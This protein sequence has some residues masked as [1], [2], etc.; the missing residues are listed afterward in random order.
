M[1]HFVSSKEVF[2]RNYMEQEIIHRMTPVSL[3][4]FSKED[5]FKEFHRKG[6]GTENHPMTFDPWEEKAS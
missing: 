2:S 6:N 1:Y 4:F 3:F 5:L